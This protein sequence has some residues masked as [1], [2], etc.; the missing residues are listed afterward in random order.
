MCTGAHAFI[1]VDNT[2]RFR[3]NF[4]HLNEQCMNVIHVRMGTAFAQADL[5]NMAQIIAEWWDT[6]LK[7]QCSP[8][9]ALASIEATSLETEEDLRI[10][11]TTGMPN[12]G[13]NASVAMPGGTT[14]AVRLT[15]AYSGRSKNGRLFHIGLTEAS[16]TGNSLVPAVQDTLIAAYEELLAAINGYGNDASLVIV[17]YCNNGSWRTTGGTV[18]VE[19][20]SVDPYIDSQRRRNHR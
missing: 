8:S 2:A 4:L 20:A 9:T 7:A 19:N 14:V 6:N 3:L 15:S 17:S 5:E 1:P 12:V 10:I 18:I 13:T 11:Y 16:V